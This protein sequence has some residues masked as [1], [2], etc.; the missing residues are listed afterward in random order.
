MYFLYRPRE[1]GYATQPTSMCLR[2]SNLNRETP[3]LGAYTAPDVGV[4][5]GIHRYIWSIYLISAFRAAAIVLFVY[6]CFLP[7]SYALK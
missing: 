7:L 1:C 4:P 6:C 2:T 3:L 5:A